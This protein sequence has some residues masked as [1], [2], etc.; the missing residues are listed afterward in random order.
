VTGSRRA[1]GE[2][3]HLSRDLAIGFE[4][5]ESPTAQALVAALMADLDERYAADG[6]GD[7][8]N[9]E[10]VGRFRVLAEQVTPP[11]GV[12]L[13]AR[14]AGEPVGC[15][16]VRAVIDGPPDV[17]EIKRMFTVP[18]ARGHGISRLLLRRLEAE[19]A[20]LGYRRLHLE[21]GLRQPE[22]IRLYESAGYQPIPTYGQYAGDELSLCF[23]KDLSQV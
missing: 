2:A 16:A 9:P 10:L 8:D 23:G 1:T 6:P 14:R 3:D 22:A 18:A 13:V 20:D 11:Q 12:F 17:A 21:T 4:P 15:G 5:F 19:A 7:G